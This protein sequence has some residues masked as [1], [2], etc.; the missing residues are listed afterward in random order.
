MVSPLIVAKA[1]AAAQGAASAQVGSAAT[2][3]SAG[4][5]FGHMVTA[6]LHDAMSASRTAETQMTA[7]M[8]GKAN[9][10][11]VVTSISSAQSSLETVMAIRDQAISAYQE[12]MRMPI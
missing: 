9:L 11:D 8:Q 12:I 6:A 3:A 10:V 4:P 7:Q 1:Y 2:A 5:D